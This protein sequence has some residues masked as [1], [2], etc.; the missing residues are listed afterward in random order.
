MYVVFT[1]LTVAAATFITRLLPFLLFPAN[2]KTPEFV[3]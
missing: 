2:K 3:L 1:I